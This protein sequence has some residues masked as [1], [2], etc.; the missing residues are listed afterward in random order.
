M[1]ERIKPV[2]A[3]LSSQFYERNKENTE[4]LSK[5]NRPYLVLLIEYRGLKFAIP[6]RSHIQHTHA[7]KFQGEG[8]QRKA[9][10]LDFSKSV[11][12][13]SDDEIGPPAH[14][15]PAERKEL[16]KRFNFIV[17]KFH[18]Y[19]DDFIEGLKKEPLQPKYRM[20]SLTFYKETLLKSEK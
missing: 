6:F 9:S 19:I 2:M 8:S 1:K 17:Q 4:I 11:L 15:I 3:L 16:L 5:Q 7:Y 18:S 10:G 14:L 13:A 20:S 12:V